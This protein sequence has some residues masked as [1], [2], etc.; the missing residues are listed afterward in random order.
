MKGTYIGIR[1]YMR[2][3]GKVSAVA[4][5]Q[6]DGHQ[7]DQAHHGV[8]LLRIKLADDDQKDTRHDADEMDP[9]LLSP[10]VVAR[11]FENQV[12]E[13]SSSRSSDDVEEAKHGSPT[14]GCGLSEVWEVLEI[15]RAEDGIDCELAAE[16]ADVSSHEGE[17]LKR[18]EDL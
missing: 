16:R 7:C 14:T 9:H 11:P 15:V 8:E 5:L 13:E 12:A 6:E 10:Q 2:H 4:C 1:V 18:A 3:K 17:G